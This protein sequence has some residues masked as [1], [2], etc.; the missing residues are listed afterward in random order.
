M[1]ELTLSGR[2][3]NLPECD[4]DKALRLLWEAKQIGDATANL[5][6]REGTPK[7]TPLNGKT[8]VHPSVDL[9]IEGGGNGNGGDDD[10]DDDPPPGGSSALLPA[11]ILEDTQTQSGSISA[12]AAARITLQEKWMK[13]AG[14]S[15]PAPLYAPGTRVLPLGD[16]NFRL[17]RKRVEELPLFRDAATALWREIRMENREDEE[18][19]M[20]GIRLSDAGLLLFDGSAYG[21][22]LD[23]FYQL[24]SLMGIGVGARYLAE[25]CSAE[26]RAYNVNRRI[27]G[28]R[29]RTV[30]LRKRLGADGTT[31]VYAA[32][33]PTYAAVDSDAVLHAVEETLSDAHT[34]ILYTGLGIRATALFMPDQVVDLAAGD[35]FKVGVRIEADDTGKGR[36]RIEG[37]VFRNRCLNLIVIGEGTVETVSLVHRGDPARILALLKE[38]AEA[39]R[40][41]VGNFLEAWGHARSV[42]IDPVKTIRSWIE[43]KKVQ[44]AGERKT[45]VLME[46]FLSAWQKEPGDTLADAVNAVTRAAHEYPLWSFNIRE[47]LERQAAQLVYVRR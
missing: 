4:L 40:G 47:E 3:E 29:N 7:V 18:V 28:I 9:H 46:I 39:A 42:K 30:K 23:A 38:G 17:E 44:V 6:K 20:K 1:L 16:E 43:E 21:L 22:E 27:E 33:T 26:L 10:D 14:F 2:V 5:V 15:A 8:V 19:P 32:V 37:V 25:L 34:E 12:Q 31:Q 45:D 36:I 35:I 41:K 24:A 11:P 13:E